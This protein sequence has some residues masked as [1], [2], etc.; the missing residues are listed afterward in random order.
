MMQFEAKLQ[1]AKADPFSNLWKSIAGDSH[2]EKLSLVVFPNTSNKN[3]AFEKSRE[4]FLS[5]KKV[6]EKWRQA[7]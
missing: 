5:K 1:T 3:P 6:V 4:E 2:S 7:L